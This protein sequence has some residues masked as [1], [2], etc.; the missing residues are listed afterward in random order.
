[1]ANEKEYMIG[2]KSISNLIVAGVK[3]GYLLAIKVIRITAD[4]RRI[5]LCRCDCGNEIEILAESLKKKKRGCGCLKNRKV[6]DRVTPEYKAWNN[7]LQRCNNS[8]TSTYKYYG[9]LGI[10]VSKDWAISFSAFLKDMGR[11]P[12]KTH[13]LDRYPNTKGNYEKGNCRWATRS[14]QDR[15]RTDNVKIK[16]NGFEM[17]LSDWAAYFNMRLGTLKDRLKRHTFKDTF[18]KF[19]PFSVLEVKEEKAKSKK[20]AFKTIRELFIKDNIEDATRFANGTMTQEESL[21]FYKK[22]NSC[23]PY[24]T[25]DNHKKVAK[26]FKNTLFKMGEKW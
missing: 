7:M 5:W 8:K 22:I 11:K 17:I 6:L 24:T 14:E 21:L 23:I 15:N 3:Y 19:T 10:T 9:A 2:E 18:N 12:S 1:M 25:L 13:S 4:K 26:T 20:S 16:F